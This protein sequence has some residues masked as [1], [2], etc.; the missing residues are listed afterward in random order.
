[1]NKIALKKY[2]PKDTTPEMF[3]KV[4]IFYYTDI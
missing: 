4:S 3:P 2:D 1:M